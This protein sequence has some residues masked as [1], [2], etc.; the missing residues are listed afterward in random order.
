MALGVLKINL[1]KRTNYIRYYEWQ[2][3]PSLLLKIQME[4]CDLA[5]LFISISNRY[6][7]DIWVSMWAIVS[8]LESYPRQRS[9]RAFHIQP[10]PRS[11][12]AVLIPLVTIFIPSFYKV[13]SKLSSGA[14]TSNIK[15]GSHFYF[16]F[17]KKVADQVFYSSP[18][19]SFQRRK[20]VKATI[21]LTSDLLE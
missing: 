21:W 10:D 13:C 12:V 17:I 15:L 3:M 14:S 8:R 19:T 1:Y 9:L 4:F 6:S 5:F 7:C 20:E 11:G 16:C 2:C 18:C